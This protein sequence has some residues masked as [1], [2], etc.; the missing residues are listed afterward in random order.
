MKLGY[1]RKLLY[2]NGTDLL[3]SRI[4]KELRRLIQDYKIMTYQLYLTQFKYRDF[5]SLFSDGSAVKYVGVIW[6]FCKV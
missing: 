5:E 2:V 3:F 1:S 6:L 4:L